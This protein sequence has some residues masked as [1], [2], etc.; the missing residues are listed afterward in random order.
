M[1]I[2]VSDQLVLP[3]GGGATGDA[4]KCP[5]YVFAPVLLVEGV[6]SSPD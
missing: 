6:H 3:K 2:V 5:V 4:M 1:R